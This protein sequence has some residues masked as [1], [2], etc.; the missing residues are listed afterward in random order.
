MCILPWFYLYRCDRFAFVVHLIQNISVNTIHT[1]NFT[2]AY[3]EMVKI[4]QVNQIAW[5]VAIKI[6]I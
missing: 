6:Y 2:E 1:T 5:I 4:S 3:Y